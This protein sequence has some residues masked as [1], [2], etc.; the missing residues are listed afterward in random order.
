MARSCKRQ[1]CA[2]PL[3][4]AGM[5]VNVADE[6]KVWRKASAVQ[7]VPRVAAHQENLARLDVVV[8]V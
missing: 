1:A 5:H 6:V 8:F 4:Y 2:A 7:H 3:E